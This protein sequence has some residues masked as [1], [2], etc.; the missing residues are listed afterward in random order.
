[1]HIPTVVFNS[2]HGPDERSVR[3]TVQNRKWRKEDCDW[4]KLGRRAGPRS[5]IGR[6]LQLLIYFSDSRCWLT[7]YFNNLFSARLI[8]EAWGWFYLFG[9]SYF[10]KDQDKNRDISFMCTFW[11]RLIGYALEID[12]VTVV[13]ICTLINRTFFINVHHWSTMSS[14]KCFYGFISV[15]LSDT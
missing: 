8:I 3:L 4:L 14:M 13:C 1:M 12:W 11:S 6:T 9:N 15:V 10:T 5:S 7:R 2:L